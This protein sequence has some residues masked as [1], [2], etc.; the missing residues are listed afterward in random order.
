[1]KLILLRDA[2]NLGKAGATIE[3]KE[4]FAKNYLIPQKIAAVLGSN[5]AN[6]VSKKVLNETKHQEQELNLIKNKLA[7]LQDNPI[8]LKVKVGPTGKLFGAITANDIIKELVKY[9]VNINAK[10]MEMDNIKSVGLHEISI[11]LAKDVKI[12]LR[13]NVIN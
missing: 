6:V 8:I 3:A 2:K 5:Q 1:M 9:G 7:K 12:K 10:Q 11:N 13:I 4:G